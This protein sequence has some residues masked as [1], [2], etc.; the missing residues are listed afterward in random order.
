MTAEPI[1]SQNNRTKINFTLEED[2][3]A[4]DFNVFKEFLYVLITDKNYEIKA[5]RRSLKIMIT[6]SSVF[7]G[8]FQ[9]QYPPRY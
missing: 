3:I 4:S 2:S 5:G 9:L 1:P 8:T 6:P 7:Y